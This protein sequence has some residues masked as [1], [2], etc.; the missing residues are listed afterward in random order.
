MLP[1]A[2]AAPATAP[3][4]GATELL[5]PFELTVFH[6]RVHYWSGDALG[7]VDALSRILAK[8]KERAREEGR[9]VVQRRELGAVKARG[10]GDAEGTQQ[11][12]EDQ[13]QDEEQDE[14]DEDA[15]ESTK[16]AKAQDEARGG[17]DMEATPRP[18]HRQDRDENE[19]ENETEGREDAE[20]STENPDQDE[21]DEEPDDVLAAAEANLSMWLER[22]ARVCLILASQM[23]EMNVGTVFPLSETPF[24][25]SSFCSRIV[26]IW[27][28]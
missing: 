14:D 7:Y 27:D 23:I 16:N 12:R 20:G 26:G 25:F 13:E 24:T 17:G 21:E 1:S 3:R 22:I 9:V 28:S 4:Q 11:A 5:H 2:F 6:A 18:E 8:C 10:G 19:N 15:E